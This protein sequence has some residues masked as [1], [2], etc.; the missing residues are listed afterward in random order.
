MDPLIPHVLL[1]T[2]SRTM[3]RERKGQQ[4]HDRSKTLENKTCAVPLVAVISHDPRPSPTPPHRHLGGGKQKQLLFLYK[5]APPSPT[6]GPRQRKIGAAMDWADPSLMSSVDVSSSYRDLAC[7]G[8]G[9][10]GQYHMLLSCSV[11]T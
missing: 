1:A 9:I 11:L 8:A 5:S 6:A 10:A 7:Y 3:T 2:R 4:Q